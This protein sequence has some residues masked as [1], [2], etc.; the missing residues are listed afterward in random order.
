MKRPPVSRWS[1]GYIHATYDEYSEKVWEVVDDRTGDVVAKYGN[2]RDA[3]NV[4][5]ELGLSKARSVGARLSSS[6]S[7]S[8]TDQLTPRAMPSWTT[9][10][11]GSPQT[12]NVISQAMRA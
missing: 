2:K 5:C 7:S 4:A 11:A 6:G 8:R 10:F 12:M 1:H 3:V 9:S